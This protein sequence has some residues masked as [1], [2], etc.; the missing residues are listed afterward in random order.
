MNY[1]NLSVSQNC[2]RI[3]KN[4]GNMDTWKLMRILRDKLGKNN[5]WHYVRFIQNRS[6]I[7]SVVISKGVKWQSVRKNIRQ[8]WVRYHWNESEFFYFDYENSNKEKRKS[9]VPE[10]EKNIFCDKANDNTSDLVFHDKWLTYLKFK[11]YFKRDAIFIYDKD[12]LLS[13]EA[14]AFFQK[15]P[16]FILKPIHAATGR[17][18]Q[19][20][21]INDLNKVDKVLLPIIEKVKACI[22]EE[23]I[24]QD[25]AFALLHPYSVNTIRVPSFR[26]S[27]NDTLIF[28]PF[29]RVGQGGNIID[30]AGAGGIMGLIDVNTGIVY[31][32]SDECQGYYEKHPDTGKDIVGFKVPQWEDAKSLIKNVAEV[33]PEVRYVGWDIAL[34]N[35]GWVL[36]EGNEKGQF[37]WQ[38]PRK[39]GFREEF[40]CIC[41]KANISI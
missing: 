28:H 6:R 20:I 12:S 41:R 38:I 25:S 8:A 32:A 30:N 39:E 7:K 13:N 15:H 14:T 33:L 29:L 19:I 37:L 3:L 17:G 2:G 26:F 27:E 36:I 23:L 22:A 1:M 10:Y 24:V 4:I 16:K 18:V 9:F 31:A 34:T 35:K 40:E 5:F 11:E 21:S